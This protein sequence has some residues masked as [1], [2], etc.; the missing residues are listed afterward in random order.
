MIAFEDLL[1][2][3]NGLEQREL[4]RWIENRWVLPDRRNDTELGE[5]RAD[6]VGQLGA[7]PE[8]TVKRRY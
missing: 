2:R 1:L 8:P 4:T 6:R 3:V 5:M 7:L